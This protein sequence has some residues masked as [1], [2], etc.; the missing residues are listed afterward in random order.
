M[1]HRSR[2]VTGPLHSRWSEHLEAA[3]YPAQSARHLEDPLL[4]PGVLAG[5]RHARR[6]VAENEAFEALNWFF[7][8]IRAIPAAGWNLRHDDTT[9]K[10]GLPSGPSRT[11]VD[12][13]LT[14]SRL[15]LGV[16]CAGG[17]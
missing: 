15:N 8:V 9:G 17:F 7:A 14:C 5:Y 4:A 13:R 16:S 10:V 2:V 6:A 3:G 1:Q 12:Q 11:G